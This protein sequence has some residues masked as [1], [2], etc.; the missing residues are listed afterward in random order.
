LI[1]PNYRVT[2]SATRNERNADTTK[3]ANIFT[4]TTRQKKS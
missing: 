1:L 2:V 3:T 4:L